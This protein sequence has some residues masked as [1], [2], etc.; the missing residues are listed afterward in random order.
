MLSL[1]GMGGTIIP[2]PWVVLLAPR[3]RG[4]SWWI[5]GGLISAGRFRFVLTAFQALWVHMIKV[6]VIP[7]HVSG[8]FMVRH[9][10]WTAGRGGFCGVCHYLVSGLRSLPRGVGSTPVCC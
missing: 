10:V 2:V 7:V 8:L 9:R 6:S 3:L 1:V 5:G 4:E